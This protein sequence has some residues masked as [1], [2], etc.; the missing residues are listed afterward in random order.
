MLLAIP[1]QQRKIFP[2]AIFS[3]VFLTAFLCADAAH[4]QESTLVI[5]PAP[6][7]EALEKIHHSRFAL[8]RNSVTL[9]LLQG[10]AELF[11]GFTTRYFVHH[12]SSCTEADPASRFLL[13]SRPNW[14]GMLVYGSLE[15]VPT[16]YLSQS[17]RTSSHKLIRRI[18]EIAPIGVIGVHLIEG[19]GNLITTP[20]PESSTRAPGSLNPVGAGACPA[21]RQLQIHSLR[22]APL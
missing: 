14:T 22:E 3:S 11:D 9:G 19:A 1:K 13:G 5:P 12:C 15:A 10:G 18:G 2:R 20:S 8:D 7:P 6:K 4:A 21:R 17:L 16:T